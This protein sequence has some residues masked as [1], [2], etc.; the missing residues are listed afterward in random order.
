MQHFLN[1]TG[2]FAPHVFSRHQ[3]YLVIF[4]Q[5]I[6]QLRRGFLN[7]DGVI[8]GKFQLS[9]PPAATLRISQASG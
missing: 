6:D 9:T 4:Y 5:Q 7:D 1:N 2:F 3:F 8:S